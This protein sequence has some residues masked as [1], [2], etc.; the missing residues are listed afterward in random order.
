MWSKLVLLFESLEKGFL[1]NVLAGAGVMLASSA[2]FMTAF[3]AVFNSFKNSLN[4]VGADLLSIAHLAGFDV[5][6]TILLSACVTKMTLNASKLS[7]R[8]A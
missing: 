3:I 6:I 1:K 4:S 8:K 7:L 2:I 5:A